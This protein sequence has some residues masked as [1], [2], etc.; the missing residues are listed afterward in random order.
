MFNRLDTGDGIR[1]IA[2]TLTTEL[3]GYLDTLEHY[4]EDRIRVFHE[5]DD[6]AVLEALLIHRGWEYDPNI[7][8]PGKI[9][10]VAQWTHFLVNQY[11]YGVPDNVT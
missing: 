7:A 6:I 2:S 3:I 11:N 9:A 4:S 5:P 10:G 8:Y 1:D